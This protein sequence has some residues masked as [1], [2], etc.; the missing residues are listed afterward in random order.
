MVL[1]SL[2]VILFFVL[3]IV[4]RNKAASRKLPISRFAFARLPWGMQQI[5]IEECENAPF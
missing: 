4:A 3:R 5:R 1:K 2:T